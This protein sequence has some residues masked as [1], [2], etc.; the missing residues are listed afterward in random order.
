MNR[1]LDG[2]SPEQKCSIVWSAWT[3]G[4]ALTV[5]VER[6]ENV[7]LRGPSGNGKTHVSI[8]LGMHALGAGYRVYFVTAQGLLDQIHL[9]RLDGIPG[10]KQN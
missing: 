10:R 7:I 3:R 5:F 9:A 6:A 2:P 4:V 1:L 8:G